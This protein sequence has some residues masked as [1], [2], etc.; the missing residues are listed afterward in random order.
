MTARRY[1]RN[2]RDANEQ[3]LLFLA[4]RLGATW[5]EA[6]PLDGWIAHRGRWICVEIKNP[7]G[8]NR[9]QPSQEAF[10]STCQQQGAPVYVWRTEDDVLR[11]LQARVTT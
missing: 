3:G 4:H 9:L 11:D 10:L 8:R 7:D 5:V 1:T 2:R 6:G